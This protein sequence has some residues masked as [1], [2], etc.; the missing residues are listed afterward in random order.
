MLVSPPPLPAKASPHGVLQPPRS[1]LSHPFPLHRLPSYLSH[2]RGMVDALF[3]R[4]ISRRLRKRDEF[5]R[6]ARHGCLNV[7]AIHRTR[8]EISKFRKRTTGKKRVVESNESVPYPR[9]RSPEQEGVFRPVFSVTAEN[10][11]RSNSKL[12]ALKYIQPV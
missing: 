3:G 1:P 6:A 12:P 11:M 7:C 2:S 10:T 5:Y 4:V 8:H 9:V